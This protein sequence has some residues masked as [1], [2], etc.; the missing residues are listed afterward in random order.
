MKIKLCLFIFLCFSSLLSNGQKSKSDEWLKNGTKLTYQ[1][2]FNALEYD[3]IVDS[4]K[5]S[6]DISFAWQMTEP[7]TMNGNILIKKNA[8]DTATSLYNYFTGGNQTF[9]DKTSVWVSKKVFKAIKK[10]SSV[11][12]DAGT[13]REKLLFV[14][15]EKLTC[16]I[17]DH[18]KSIETLKAVTESGKIIWIL[19]DPLHPIIVKMNLGWTLTLKSVNN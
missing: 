9:E 6:S 8:L 17:D 5:V 18:Q 15:E 13:G 11:I 7:M 4:I 2:V 14:A 16:T 12:V 3:F 10:G 19:D 1:V